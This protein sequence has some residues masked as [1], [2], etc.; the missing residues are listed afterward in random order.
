MRGREEFLGIGPRPVLEAAA[1]AEVGRGQHARLG[2]QGPLAVTAVALPRSA[3]LADHWELLVT[4][5]FRGLRER[6][7][8]WKKVRGL[9]RGGAPMA[10]M[11]Q[12]GRFRSF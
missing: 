12:P 11:D 1:V 4:S 10:Q 3:R 9:F 2:G 5:V 8:S 6:L 7:V